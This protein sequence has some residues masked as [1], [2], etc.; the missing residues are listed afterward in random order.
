MTVQQFKDKYRV[1][2]TIIE[3]LDWLYLNFTKDQ[4]LD[5]IDDYFANADDIWNSIKHN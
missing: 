4:A 1:P 5:I 2:N 3:A